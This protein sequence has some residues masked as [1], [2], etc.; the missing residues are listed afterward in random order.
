LLANCV[1]GFGFSRRGFRLGLE[2]A[3]HLV[4]CD[5]GSTDFGPGFLGSGRD[6]KSRLS[7]ERDL[8]IMVTGAASAEAPLVIGSCGGAGAEAHLAGFR[9]IVG[10]IARSAGLRLKVAVIH[11]ELDRATIHH[12]LDDGRTTPLGDIEPLTHAAIDESAAIV[13]MMGAGPI[14]DA[15]DAGADVVLA[16]RCADPAIFASGALRLGVPEA[17]AWHAAKSID[18]GYLATTEPSKGSPVLA[19]LREDHFVIEPMLPDAVCT[20]QTVAR[21]TMHENPDPFAIVQ[22]T[23]AIAA[24]DARYEQVD[25]R[26]VRVSGSRFEHAP[27]PSIKIEGARLV[28]YRAVMIAGI[29]DPR[30]LEQLD[31]FL[32]EY[33]A[34]LERV[35]A[36][37]GISPAQWSL[38]FRPY[39]HDAVL[40][41]LEPSRA[42]PP[43]EVGLVVDVVADTEDIA[44]AIAGRA[45]ATGSRLDF[46]GRLG[47]GGNFAYPFS[48]NVLRGGP[49]YEWSVWH[50]MEV[51]DERDPFRIELIEIA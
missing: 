47:G 8:R 32:D 30:L 43:H 15:L 35:V 18:K 39:G 34:L 12:A 26:T 21:I 48:P 37:L 19:T 29:R 40:R 45:A 7:S 22:P 23:G 10:D 46:T 14:I 50:V 2:R 6:P 25:K 27:R 41:D 42:M 5:S 31:A 51:D 24:R 44:G 11:A 9:A 1:V 17:I 36:S 4:G 28:G 38:R 16:G 33:R 20:T 3:P 13:G 49:V